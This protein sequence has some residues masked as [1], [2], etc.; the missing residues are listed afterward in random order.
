MI[1]RPRKPPPRLPPEPIRAPPCLSRRKAT[2]RVNHVG[3]QARWC[4]VVPTSIVARQPPLRRFLRGFAA[5][6]SIG[7]DACRTRALA[8]EA[9]RQRFPMP[10]SIGS[11]ACRGGWRAPIIVCPRKPP[12]RLPP[13]LQYARWRAPMIVRP[14]KTLPRLPPEPIRAPPCLS[15]R[16]ATVRVNHV[17]RQA[18]WCVVVPTSIVARQPPLRFYFLQFI[19]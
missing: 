1:V 18:R 9:A 8:F 2:V 12:P 14:R 3:R 4:V 6:A 15:R 7:S 10:A 11:E 5:F 13:E 17:G 19:A 16:K